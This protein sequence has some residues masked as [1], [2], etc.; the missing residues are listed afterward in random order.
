MNK[1]EI[2]QEVFSSR[3]GNSKDSETANK[4]KLFTVRDAINSVILFINS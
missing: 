1:Y 4:A 3:D 2:G